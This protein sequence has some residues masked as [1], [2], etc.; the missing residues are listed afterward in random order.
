M[1]NTFGQFLKQTRLR[2]GFGL[3]VFAGMVDMKP[4]NL[5][6]IEHGRRNP[7][8]EGDKL[9]EIAEALGL[10]KGSAD[11]ATF[12]DL[13]SQADGLPADVRHMA[14]RKPVPALLRAIH[15]RQLSDEAIEKLIDHIEHA[16]GG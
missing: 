6:A 14:R 4:S 16:H 8:T 2:A 12:F 10:T 9:R 1:D 13:A 15:E 3:R 7:P 5:S 11:W